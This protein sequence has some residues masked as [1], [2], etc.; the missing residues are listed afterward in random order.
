[1]RITRLLAYRR[2]FFATMA[3]V[4]LSIGA[5]CVAVQQF[6]PLIT[7]TLA[8]VA[9]LLAH[10]HYAKKAEPEPPEPAYV[11]PAGVDDRFC[12]CPHC[13]H[14]AS[15]YILRIEASATTRK[16][17][18]CGKEW[19]LDH[20]EPTNPRKVVAQGDMAKKLQTCPGCWDAAL[21]SE[22]TD[23]VTCKVCGTTWKCKPGFVPPR[24]LTGEDAAAQLAACPGCRAAT[25][26]AKARPGEWIEC[27][28]CDKPVRYGA[29]A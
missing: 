22:G 23:G 20:S 4:Y 17:V 29:P 14:L 15:H 11:A 6:I 16:C 26:T 5:V 27:Q 21:A 1:M 9:G 25:E 2:T 12:S 7:A 8:A 24:L 13:A 3:L 18:N 19:T 10:R 28:T